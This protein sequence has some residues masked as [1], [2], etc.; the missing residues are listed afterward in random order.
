MRHKFDIYE[1]RQVKNKEW[2]KKVFLSGPGVRLHASTA[3]ARF[4]PWFGEL[5]PHMPHDMARKN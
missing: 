3:G 5:R 1:H 4:D 2:K